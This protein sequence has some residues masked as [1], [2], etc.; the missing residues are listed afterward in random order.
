MGM[1]GRGRW[2][3]IGM[4]T[5]VA[6]A[7]AQA[8][9]LACP[10]ISPLM[11]VEDPSDT[12]P[13]APVADVA[14]RWN[15]VGESKG[16]CSHPCP[17]RY[18][19][20]LEV[21][22]GEGE[23]ADGYVVEVVGGDAPAIEQ[24]GEPIGGQSIDLVYDGD[25]EDPE[26]YAF[27]VVLTPIDAAGNVGPASEPIRVSNEEETGCRIGWRR[28]DGALPLLVLLLLGARSRGR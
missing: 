17:G 15:G 25:P 20:S 9:A 19:F 27:T 13:P 28:A 26:T 5:G 24:L 3:R 4:M 11:L 6:W 23:P 10:G 21:T 7:A 8:V 2:I 16:F 1:A 14:V 18:S 12:T 22:P